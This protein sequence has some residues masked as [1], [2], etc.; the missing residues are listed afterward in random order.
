MI[1]DTA[2]P[3]LLLRFE[4]FP[5]TGLFRMWN[6]K[7]DPWR[8]TQPAEKTEDMVV[9][10]GFPPGDHHH[11]N[12]QLS[13]LSSE[14]TGFFE[15][16]VYRLPDKGTLWDFV[17]VSGERLQLRFWVNAEWNQVNLL[18]DNTGTQGM[19]AFEYLA[20]MMPGIHLNHD[21]LTFHA[22]LVEYA[23]WA[24]AVCASSGTGKTTHA[25]L[26][27]DY[28]NAIILNGDRM[29]CDC[30]QQTWMAYGSPWSGT[31]GEQINRSAPLK[32]LVVL[33]RGEQNEAT[34]ITGLEA[35]GA[36]LPHILYP[37]WDIELTGKALELL[38]KFLS[39]IPAVRL[40][41]RPDKES[42]DVLCRFLE[43]L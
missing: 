25:R 17:R 8:T 16:R 32:A 2:L 43:E 34:H 18:A 28:K 35:F 21:V 42:V 23:G 30:Q 31:S 5:S 40:R 19:A 37:S 41:C 3:G 4:D 11:V 38:D 27:R 24:F 6:W 29:I 26:W 10:S 39:E 1:Q 12:E 13:V 20:Q 22:S 7:I 14:R 9:I 15:R 36:I 33:E